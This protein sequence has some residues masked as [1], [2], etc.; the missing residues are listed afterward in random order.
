M[1]QRFKSD[2]LEDAV[3][4]TYFL[5]RGDVIDVE[6]HF[7]DNPADDPAILEQNDYRQYAVDAHEWFC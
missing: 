7:C 1:Q 5:E 6:V 3:V 4:A 2:V